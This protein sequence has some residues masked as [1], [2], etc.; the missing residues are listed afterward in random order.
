MLVLIT[1]CGG[2]VGPH[3]VRAL[4]TRGHR[5][6]GAGLEPAPPASLTGDS[7]VQ[8]WTR[9]DVRTDAAAIAT[10]FQS[11]GT[12]AVG[13]IVHLA[14]Q[15]SAARSFEDPVG[16]TDVNLGG[17]IR[18]LEAARSA[19]FEGPILVVGSSE[20]YGRIPAGTPANE[21][22]PL[23]PV[24]P[25]GVSKAA[26]DQAARAWASAFGLRTLVARSFS[27]TGPGQS[28]VFALPSWARQ[29]AGFEAE[30]ARGEPGPF[31]LK[32]GNLAP[33]RDYTDVRDVAEAY[34]L[35]LERGEAGRAYNVASGSGVSL[36]VIAETLARHARVP[37]EIVEEAARLRPADLLY[38]VGDS[39]RLREATG[40]A[41][42]H[43]LD[44]TLTALL[45]DARSRA[46][47]L[48]EGGS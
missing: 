21:D 4:A 38:L 11:L 45:E 47:S 19:K 34:G 28:P 9:W 15:S 48:V 36:R 32:V 23:A 1:G 35:L 41:P 42:A 16:T 39:S 18:L 22:L 30:A 17:T 25:Y 20:A 3:L 27:H 6:W 24:S 26:A 5:A 33:V 29:I 12:G 7:A 40:W 14:G 10:L 46:G 8:G 31:R 44:D 37:V 13:A 2:F 43:G